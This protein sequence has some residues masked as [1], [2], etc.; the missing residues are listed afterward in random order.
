MQHQDDDYQFVMKLI[1]NKGYRGLKK[2][3][4]VYKINPVVESEAFNLKDKYLFFH[5]VT[6]NEV[7]DILENGYPRDEEAENTSCESINAKRNLYPKE[8]Y[9]MDGNVP[10]KLS[11]A[12][13]SSSGVD[14][15]EFR[16]ENSEFLKDSRGVCIDVSGSNVSSFKVFRKVCEGGKRMTSK[17]LVTAV[18]GRAPAYLLVF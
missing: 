14:C 1:E 9:C 3:R 8:S 5:G 15:E 4:N 6:S 18:C 12:F 2:V 7:G 17:R 13:V 11:F 10:R 16:L